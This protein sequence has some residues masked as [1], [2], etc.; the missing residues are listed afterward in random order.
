MVQCVPKL[1]IMGYT[2]A[3][4]YVIVTCG[5]QCDLSLCSMGCSAAAGLQCFMSWCS[6][7]YNTA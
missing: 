4:L 6:V 1:L 7:G 5:L 2:G 3:V